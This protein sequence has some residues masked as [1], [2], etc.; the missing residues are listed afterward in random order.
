VRS[1]F[2]IVHAQRLANASRARLIQTTE[3]QQ[4]MTRTKLLQLWQEDDGVMS[5]EWTMLVTLLVI[6]VISGIAGARD[7]IIDEFS[8]VS[9]ATVNWD[10]SYSLPAAVILDSD[11][12]PAF[13]LT[14][15][16]FADDGAVFTDCGR[17]GVAGQGSETDTDS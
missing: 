14:E 8:D 7:A 1:L 4:S 12:A 10:Q 11:G 3:G 5:F 13:T 2:A 16:T 17:G 9:E 6:G 15:Q